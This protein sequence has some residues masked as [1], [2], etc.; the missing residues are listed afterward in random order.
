LLKNTDKNR[1][2]LSEV[3][4]RI[5]SWVRAYAGDALPDEQA[6][7]LA[8]R[9]SRVA[10]DWASCAPGEAAS[11]L[12]NVKSEILEEF[13]P[14]RPLGASD[15]QGS[16]GKSVV[17]I[18]E[19]SGSEPLFIDGRVEGSITLRKS[20]VTVGPSG[21]VTASIDAREILILGKVTG[22]IVAIDR[23]E[24]RK[25]GSLIG[26]AAA[27]RIIIEEGAFVKGRISMGVA[28]RAVGQSSKDPNHD[29]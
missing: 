13:L 17:I 26:D 28:A 11:F 14:A 3:H 4:R 27:G 8:D 23:V 29:L 6:M 5:L 21:V 7:K 2:Q 24:I 19:L 9:L 1:D 20:R 16:V 12:E 22:D 18:G 25:H 15:R 10:S